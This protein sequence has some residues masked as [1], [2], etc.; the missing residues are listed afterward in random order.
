MASNNLKSKFIYH[1]TNQQ[2]ILGILEEKALR[3]TNIFYLNDSSEYHH[4]INLAKKE[5][6][7]RINKF[8]AEQ[9]KIKNHLYLKTE[10]E[11][12]QKTLIIG[13]LKNIIKDIS[14][15]NDY[16]QIFVCS[17][18]EKKDHLGQWRAYGNNENGYSIGFDSAKFKKE[19]KD[20]G[21]ILE[22]CTY[23]LSE[24]KSKISH[25]VDTLIKSLNNSSSAET[26][27]LKDLFSIA[28]TFKRNSFYQE[29]EW[30]L[31]SQA[32][33]DKSI[34]VLFRPGKS[35]IIPYINCSVRNK[36]S[37]SKIIIGPTPRK[38]LAEKSIR[39]VLQEKKLKNIEVMHSKC[40][41]RTL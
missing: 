21:F 12:V 33:H 8:K 26:T 34:K 20:R 1:Y 19:L 5:I 32:I 27:F 18:S 28:P 25:L 9:S 30:R 7:K 14:S 24:K 3:A 13:R 40:T 6:E 22:P 11:Q 29:Y 35:V 36:T 17:F 37:I 23:K 38:K 31:I 15:F 39:L 10:P 4:A 2:G 16:I 41:T